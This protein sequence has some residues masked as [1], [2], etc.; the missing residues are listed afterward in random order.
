MNIIIIEK[1]DSVQ[2]KDK[3]IT[4]FVRGHSYSY[5]L[6]EIDKMTLMLNDIKDSGGDMSLSVRIEE[7]MFIIPSEY[8]DFEDFLLNNVCMNIEVDMEAVTKAF[9][10]TEKAE[11]VIYQR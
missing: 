11:F 7:N 4:F 6:S 3:L 2:I 8:G 10:C 5:F 9:S 1:D